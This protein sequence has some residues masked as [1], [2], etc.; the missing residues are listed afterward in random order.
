MHNGKHGIETFDSLYDLSEQSFTQD[1]TVEVCHRLDMF[2]TYAELN[3]KNPKLARFWIRQGRARQELKRS[4][5]Y[6]H[7]F[8]VARAC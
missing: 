6:I 4:A 7:S 1:T 2:L 5:V 8:T 3:L